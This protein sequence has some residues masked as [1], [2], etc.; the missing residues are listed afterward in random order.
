MYSKIISSLD[1]WTFEY[2][3]RYRHSLV[4]VV[5]V[6]YLIQNSSD[7]VAYLVSKWVVVGHIGEVHNS[8]R[9]IRVLA[10]EIL[11]NNVVD[12]EGREKEKMNS[13]SK[14]KRRSTSKSNR[15][16][17]NVSKDVEEPECAPNKKRRNTTSQSNNKSSQPSNKKV[18]GAGM[19]EQNP[20]KTGKNY[21]SFE[22]FRG[23]GMIT[24]NPNK[25]KCGQFFDNRL[26]KGK[27]VAIDYE[28]KLVV[29]RSI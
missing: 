2:P 4:V 19:K 15:S 28:Q 16:L 9:R 22:V 20:G 10:L 14:S 21:E 13:L 23:F 1:H 12:W 5:A 24:R 3:Y 8:L 27:I 25:Y 18:C 11:E 17:D 26:A 6:S 7:I 29:L